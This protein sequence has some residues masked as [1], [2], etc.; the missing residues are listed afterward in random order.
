MGTD[1]FRMARDIRPEDV[2]GVPEDLMPRQMQWGIAAIC[3][4]FGV[5]SFHAWREAIGELPARVTC[6]VPSP[7]RRWPWPA[8]ARDSSHGPSSMRSSAGTGWSGHARSSSL[9]RTGRRPTGQ[10]DNLRLLA[11]ITFDWLDEQLL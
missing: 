8:T 10:S 6:W 9:P 4:R 11:Q 2:I 1:M 5:P 3:H 7:A